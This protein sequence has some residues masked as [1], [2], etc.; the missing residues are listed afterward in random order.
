MID[1]TSSDEHGIGIMNTQTHRAA[2]LL[3]V[4]LG[5]LEYA[6][7]IGID[8]KYFLQEDLK[9]QNESF[10]AYLIQNLAE[11]GINVANLAES[12]EALS[13]TYLFSLTPDE[14]G[15]GLIAR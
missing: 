8:L 15:T 6:P 1:I 7:N 4:Q 11:K 3:Q 5:S 12:I 10:Q 14:T 13:S 9:F 2:N